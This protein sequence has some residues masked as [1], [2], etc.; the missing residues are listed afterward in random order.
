MRT[1]T[2]L[3]VRDTVFILNLRPTDGKYRFRLFLPHRPLTVFGGRQRPDLA[4]GDNH[5]INLYPF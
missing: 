1:Q 2:I 5:A 4:S 3:L